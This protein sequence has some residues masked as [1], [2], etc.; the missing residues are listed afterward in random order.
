MSKKY[1]KDTYL[2]QDNPENTGLIPSD[3]WHVQQKRPIN[4]LRT[5]LNNTFT[6]KGID[7]VVKDHKEG[8]VNIEYLEENQKGIIEAYSKYYGEG[9]KTILK[10]ELESSTDFLGTGLKIHEDKSPRSIQ[11]SNKEWEQYLKN[12]GYNDYC[13]S[14]EARPDILVFD[15]D[16]T[17]TE[18]Q[19]Q[20]IEKAFKKQLYVIEQNT[21]KGTSHIYLQGEDKKP[22]TKVKAG[23]KQ[24]KED[25]QPL[26]IDIF[27]G[28]LKH[29]ACTTPNREYK[30]IYDG[31][32]TNSIST[33]KAI[34]LLS[35][36]LNYYLDKNTLEEILQ[37][38]QQKK[39]TTITPTATGEI[40]VTTND[41]QSN[42]RAVTIIEN[43]IPI[44][45]ALAGEGVREELYKSLSGTLLNHG[46]NNKDTFQIMEQIYNNTNDQDPRMT[47][48]QNAIDRY[49][50]GLKVTGWKTFNEVVKKNKGKRRIGGKVQKIADSI[51]INKPQTIKKVNTETEQVEAH[52]ITDNEN[53]A[54]VILVDD[55][56]QIYTDH[57]DTVE[58]N[59]D[60]YTI[61]NPYN[62]YKIIVDYKHKH[63]ARRTINMNKKGNITYED[64]LI[65]T[66]V[67]KN[68]EVY[69]DTICNTGKSYKCTWSFEDG[70]ETEVT[71]DVPLH[72]KTLTKGAG[73][74]TKNQL[75]NTISAIFGDLT[76]TQKHN[77]IIKN[78]PLNKGFYYDKEH[79]EIIVVDH[80]I[81]RPT[82]EQLTEAL[83]LLDTYSSF[84]GYGYYNPE[85]PR[86]EGYIINPYTNEKMQNF[87]VDPT[88]L[89]V[90]LRWCLNAPFHFVRKQFG[91]TNDQYIFLSGES[92]VGKT[93]GYSVAGLF[94]LGIEEPKE[95]LT[96]GGSNSKAQI[97]KSLA[98]T[99]FPVFIDEADGILNNENLTSMLKHSV[100]SLNSRVVTDIDTNTLTKEKALAPIG[101]SANNLFKDTEKGALTNRI[102]TLPFYSR[103]VPTKE[104]KKRF[105]KEFN[106]DYTPEDKRQILKYIGYEFQARILENPKVYIHTPPDQVVK[107]FFIDICHE[108]NILSVLEWVN[109][110]IEKRTAEDDM[111]NRHEN[112]K[113]ILMTIFNREMKFTKIKNDPESYIEKPL[114]DDFTLTPAEKL[115]ALAETCK[116][117]WLRTNKRKNCFIIRK[118]VIRAVNKEDNSINISNLE[119]FRDILIFG[120]YSMYDV[121]KYAYNEDGS[122]KQDRNSVRLDIETL[123]DMYDI[124]E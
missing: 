13:F 83:E 11:L 20:K 55:P 99:T 120:Q 124:E 119:E 64:T 113:D 92:G 118:G 9:W 7:Q 71:G 50:N 46:F 62:D 35:K 69:N 47:T 34:T 60:I 41:Q 10:N 123:S 109:N 122:T 95:Y 18:D 97:S 15:F 26:D 117:S 1:L 38:K 51:F 89:A 76:R 103:D 91:M 16:I 14:C 82:T 44:F 21:K 98:K 101:F 81:Q 57:P 111:K 94:M 75:Q 84:F 112:L 72:Y 31:K 80:E 56:E 28:G 65:I 32:P 61:S 66:A 104:M 37:S 85:E 73:V 77:T 33:R 25:K 102:I 115:L 96:S 107:Q 39:T 45:K 74:W 12:G 106:T 68:L 49:Q 4:P 23:L 40:S 53:T 87:K 59:D 30:I 48:V 63:I 88:R 19:F 27:K 24:S 6:R 90:F 36:A 116:I 67:P 79:E 2:I 86:G 43:A 78:T 105:E 121:K 93:Y 5:I 8:L 110:D 58:N 70:T 52:I 29:I 17:L 42:E 54:K 114:I 3:K 100:Q 22:I 108:C